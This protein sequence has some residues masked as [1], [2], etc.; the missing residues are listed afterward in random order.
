MSKMFVCFWRTYNVNLYIYAV[1]SNSIPLSCVVIN[2]CTTK[3]VWYGTRQLEC[4]YLS[5]VVIIAVVFPPAEK[6]SS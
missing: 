2:R 6:K 1:D 3:W 4:G 5:G